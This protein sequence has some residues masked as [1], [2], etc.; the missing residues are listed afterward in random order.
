MS[1][2]AT[3]S[4]LY[5]GIR[6]EARAVA[7]AV[8]PISAEADSMST[9]HP[10]VLDA[11]RKSDLS[12]LMV[13]AAYGGRFEKVDPLAVCVVREELMAVCSHLDS[14]FGLQ[15][16]GSFAIS[17]GG[18]QEQRERWLPQ[19]AAGEVLPALALTEPSVGSDLKGMITRATV[20]GSTIELTGEKSWISNAGAAAFYT[21]L[22][23]EGDGM[24]TFLV[25]ADTPGVSVSPLADLAAPHVLG[26]VSFDHVQLDDSHR[27]GLAGGGLELVLSTL[28]VFRISVAGASIGLARTAIETARDHANTREQFG[29]PLVRLGPVAGLLADSWADL[30]ATRLLTYEAA[31]LAKEDPRTNLEYSSLAKLAATEACGRIVD[32]CTQVMGRFGLV[33]DSRIERCV[34]QARPMRVYEGA[35]EVIRLGVARKL[36]TEESI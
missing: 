35:S 1:V 36:S 7:R 3:L 34:R 6:E 4:P 16:I 8:E 24:S 11:L 21:V 20:Q 29:K 26:N 9:V 22:A 27:I 33:A 25:P 19:V 30:A 18:S 23:R 2:L 13:P 12:D 28:A 14:L 31:K 5:E 17:V 15:G 10:D 32:R